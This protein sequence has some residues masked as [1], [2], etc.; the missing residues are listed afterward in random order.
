MNYIQKLFLQFFN[1]NL[2]LILVKS[3][4]RIRYI[5]V[6]QG[7]D[8]KE[9][10]KN[11]HYFNDLLW[12]NADFPEFRKGQDWLASQKWREPINHF[13]RTG[14]RLEISS[15]KP[16]SNFTL[17]KKWHERCECRINLQTSFDSISCII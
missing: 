8:L 14:L 2:T 12:F 3:S 5:N 9:C 17:E 1:C 4:F 11:E 15:L 10:F 16:H 7:N 6:N 13:T